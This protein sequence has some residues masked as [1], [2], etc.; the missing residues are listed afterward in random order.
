M[1]SYVQK[2]LADVWKSKL[3]EDLESGEVNFKSAG[4]FLLE[5]KKEFGRENEESVKVVDL[6]RIEQGG[7]I[8]EEFVQEFKR[9]ARG[10]GYKG[11]VLIEEFKRGING[12]I[13]RKLMEVKRPS[14][15]IE[16]WY[17]CAINLD[18]YQRESR[19]EKGRLRG[20][21]EGGNQGQKQQMEAINNQGRFR[22]YLFPL[23][24]WPRRQEMQR[25]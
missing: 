5:L 19:R 25:V 24:V 22:L 13:R 7:K 2:G 16:Q 11:R 23:Q 12:V 8:I 15:S 6:K 1:L 18:K 17:N 20:R 10:S 21:K 3:L 4:K 9:I 14:T